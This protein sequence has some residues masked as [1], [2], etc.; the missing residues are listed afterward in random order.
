MRRAFS[1]VELLVVIS[2]IA[3]LSAILFPVF[4]AAKGAAYQMVCVSNTKQLGQALSTY[5]S[6]NDETYM[7]AMGADAQGFWGWFG[8]PSAKGTDESTGILL[9]Y[10]GKRKITDPQALKTKEYLGDHSGFG[11]NWGWI[12]SDMRITGRTD[13]FPYCLAPAHTGELDHPSNTVTFATSDYYSA[14]WEGG[15]GQDYDFGFVDP[16]GYRPNNPN[17]SFHYITPRRVEPKRVVNEGHAVLVFADGRAR[18]IGAK[19][20]KDDWFMRTYP[21]NQPE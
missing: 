15:D 2:I 13:Q 11:Y 5:T 19:A 21:T 6:D 9:M 7:P 17:V 14:K 3:I 18:S 12:G 16:V 20:L 10:E 4:V 8:R 1:L